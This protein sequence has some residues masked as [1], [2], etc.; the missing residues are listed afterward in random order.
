DRDSLPEPSTNPTYR[1]QPGD[2]L[3]AIAHQHMDP[4]ASP[5]EIAQSWP[6]WYSKN[7][8]VIGPDPNLIQPGMVLKQPPKEES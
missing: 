4:K 2:T 1:V 5:T 8:D 6:R 3:W 7:R